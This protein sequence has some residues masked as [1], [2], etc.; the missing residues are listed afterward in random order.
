[1]EGVAGVVVEPGD[2]FSVGPG[3]SVGGGE[4]VV[5]EV[6]LPAFVGLVG[7]EVC[8]GG[9]GSF[10]GFGGDEAVA[11]EDA[12]DCGPVENHVVGVVQMPGESFGS[13]VEA[14]VGEAVAEVEDQGHGVWWGGG[15]GVLGSSGVGLER[16]VAFRPVAGH[17]FGDPALGDAVAAGGFGL[18][19]AR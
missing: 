8:V 16:S 19:E 18:G 2:D 17:E 14:G 4:A 3:E 10:A 13:R 12:V 11:G 9:F 15:G 5:G 7:L 1:M 6:G